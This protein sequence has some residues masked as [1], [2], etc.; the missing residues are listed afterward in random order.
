MPSISNYDQLKNDLIASVTEDESLK[1]VVVGLNLTAVESK[2]LGMA[3]TVFDLKTSFI[4][5]DQAGHFHELTTLQLI[6]KLKSKNV[7]EASLGM[8]AL[9]SM[10]DVSESMESMNA[11]KII[12]EKGIAKNI[13]VIGHFPFVE[14][15]K[16]IYKNCWVFEKRPRPGDYHADDMFS[17][18]PLCDVVVITGQTIINGSIENILGASIQAFK[19]M[20]GP[21][22]PLNS[23]LFDYGIDDITSCLNFLIEEGIFSKTGKGSGQKIDTKG[24]YE[25]LSE[26]ELNALIDQ[27]E[28]GKAKGKEEKIKHIKDENSCFF[29]ADLINRIENENKEEEIKNLVKNTWDRIENEI[30]TQRKK[31]F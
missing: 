15:L 23:V 25:N 29:M 3:S 30:K 7:L 20:L 16:K 1:D 14:R 5:M 17:F 27:I 21:S 8:A 28:E 22:T 19:I 10:I 2:N 24:A 13:G 31:R 18:L 4:K 12:E 6:R 9:N 11:Y 26:K